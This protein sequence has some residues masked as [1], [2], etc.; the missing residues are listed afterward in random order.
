ML[1]R[2][3]QQRHADKTP[4]GYHDGTLASVSITRRQQQKRG[5]RYVPAGWDLIDTYSGNVIAEFNDETAPPPATRFRSSA[6]STKLGHISGVGTNPLQPD[7]NELGELFQSIYML[8][9]NTTIEALQLLGQAIPEH[10]DSPDGTA[11]AQLVVSAYTKLPQ[12]V[13]MTKKEAFKA[14]YNSEEPF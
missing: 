1:R 11:I 14:G 10:K 5:K 6:Y 13:N 7:G 3:K 12:S 2:N 9:Y 4:S 8:C